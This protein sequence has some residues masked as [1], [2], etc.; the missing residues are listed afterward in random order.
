VIV[1]ACG[2]RADLLE[3]ARAS[4]RAPAIAALCER[5]NFAGTIATPA[6]DC[7]AAH[8]S[9]FLGVPPGEHR[10]RG[11]A[12]DVAAAAGSSFISAARSRGA[13][14]AAFLSRPLV[15]RGQTG[16]ELDFGFSTF[17]L[18]PIPRFSLAMFGDEAA[19]LE[20]RRDDDATLAAALGWLAHAGTPF[21]LWVQLDALALESGAPDGP[22][23]RTAAFDR[24]AV[25]D[26]AVAR[27]RRE[28]ERAGRERRTCFILTADHGEA[29]G[30]EGSFGH[31]MA[32]DVVAH[33]PLIVADP[34]ERERWRDPPA[35]LTALGKRLIARFEGRVPPARPSPAPIDNANPFESDRPLA[36]EFERDRLPLTEAAARSALPKLRE[37]SAAHPDVLPIAESYLAALHALESPSDEEQAELR[38]ARSKWLERVAFG[39]PH[40]PLAAALYARFGGEIGAT[41]ERRE[42]AAEQ[43]VRAAPWYFPAVRALAVSLSLKAP[44]RAA[45]VLEAFGRSAPLTPAARAEF[46][47]Q[48]EKTHLGG[49]PLRD[50][51]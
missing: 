43:A 3:E 4:G 26:R 40:R 39:M 12:S 45:A 20:P 18:P 47:L 22:Q 27:L 51:K 19:A 37:Q 42:A 30:E 38:A 9:L 23:L 50:P 14:T 29:L 24:I 46:T 48:L 16:S 28:L 34:E 15:A 21:V 10:I 7:L 31:R 6:V 35:D 33:V 17:D 25:L 49:A 41:P 32:L 5:A 36:L 2:L 11:P 8:A 1:T 13:A 44:T